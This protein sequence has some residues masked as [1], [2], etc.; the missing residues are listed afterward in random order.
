MRAELGLLLDRDRELERLRQVVASASAGEGSVLF[1]EGDPGAGKSALVTAGRALAA[2]A[3]LG[4]M[5][6]RATELER[7]HPYGIARQWFGPPLRSLEPDDRAALLTGPGE[8][9]LTVLDAAAV[10]AASSFAALEGLYWVL[11]GLAE[12]RPLL[13]VLDDAQWAD[14]D[15]R[16]LLAFLAPRVADLPVALVVTTR[17]GE[18]DDDRVVGPLRDG[19]TMTLGPLS[20]AAVRTLVETHLGDSGAPE[21]VTACHRTTGGN[22]FLVHAL[23]DDLHRSGVA[24]TTEAG[25]RVVTLGP[26]AVATAVVARLARLSE[27]TPRVAQ[28]L[29]VL[30]DG[31]ARAELAAVA[32]VELDQL[33]AALDELE[34][35][36]LITAD[37]DPS[38][39]HAITANAVRNDMGRSARTELHRRAI[40]VLTERKAEPDRIAAHLIA[41]GTPL[42]GDGLEVLRAAAGDAL[43]RGASEVAVSYLRRALPDVTDAAERAALLLELSQAELFVD[44]PAALSHL[45]EALAITED[46]VQRVRIKS[47]LAQ[48]LLFASRSEDAVAMAADAAEDAVAL[49]DPDLIHRLEALQ[50][51]PAR[52]EPAMRDTR[53]A[54]L[55]H[56]RADGVASDGVGARMLAAGMVMHESRALAIDAATTVEQA[57]WSL[58]DSILVDQANGGADFIG[59]VM[60]LCTADSPLARDALNAGLE[61]ARATGDVFARAACSIFL[62]LDHLQR[63]ELADAIFHGEAG[64][65]ASEAYGLGIGVPWGSGYLALAYV[66]AGDLDQA[67]AT[68]NRA[69]AGG[70]VPDNGVWHAFVHARAELLLARRDPEAALAAALDAGER[71]ERVEGQNPGA[72]PWRTAA[73]QALLIIGNERDRAEAL[74]R[75]E[76]ERARQFGAPRALGRALRVLGLVVGGED[77]RAAL[78]ESEEV[79]RGSP[80]VLELALTLIERGAAAR[81]GNQRAAAR[82]VLTEALTLARRCGAAPAAARAAE[83]LAAAGGR[84]GKDHTSPLASLTPS[85]RR[86]AR[87]AADGATNRDIAQRLYVTTKTVEFHLGQVYR[88]LG[89]AGRAD[90][91]GQLEAPELQ[92]DGSLSQT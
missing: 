19:I 67:E 59:A 69:S 39:V 45:Q 50:F 11:A 48:G 82:P 20:E 25:A 16:R 23:L 74:A 4:V 90:L 1:V 63:G 92:I 22:P 7:E 86:V 32:E 12:R 72:M 52:I 62:G 66:M 42:D 55:E 30:G 33:V 10:P 29:S 84:P 78:A 87:L 15:S 9:A 76:V 91:A 41:A 27:L 80:A 57:S 49:G 89:I 6:A 73:A 5:A 35:A 3:G 28:A 75:D 79:L 58:A 2:E 85:E 61:R 34:R 44:G 83:E 17:T 21:F 81:R 8:H 68:L 24:P 77:G 13:L 71:F 64:L 70:A 65:S 38:F 46:P 51:A 14:A 47:A 54:L 53:S 36:G 18:L 37:D 43:D 26:R 56:Y 60:A 31:V 40:A 88:K